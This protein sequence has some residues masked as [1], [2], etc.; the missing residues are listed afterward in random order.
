MLLINVLVYLIVALP[1][2]WYIWHLAYPPEVRLVLLGALV[3]GMVDGRRRRRARK[4][5]T[6][7]DLVD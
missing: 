6:F 1:L 5:Q 2:G 3:L 7:R 4:L